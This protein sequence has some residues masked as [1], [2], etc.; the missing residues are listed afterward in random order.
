VGSF[1]VKVNGAA[2]IQFVSVNTILSA[3]TVGPIVSVATC[4]V[5]GKVFDANGNPV[6]GAAVVARVLNRPALENDILVTD[7]VVSVRTNASGEFFLEL[8]RLLEVEITIS[9]GNYRR[10][11]TVPNQASA[12]LFTGI[13]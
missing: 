9:V 7:D 3:G 13:P 4:V 6:V 10:Q 5:T 11:L 8:V 2:I 12:D 1:T